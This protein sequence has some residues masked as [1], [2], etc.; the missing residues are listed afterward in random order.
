MSIADKR[1][2]RKNPVSKYHE[3]RI[4]GKSLAEALRRK[5]GDDLLDHLKAKYPDKYETL[6]KLVKE[7]GL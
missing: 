6:V 2:K 7:R 3:V 4:Y 5:Y 1:Y